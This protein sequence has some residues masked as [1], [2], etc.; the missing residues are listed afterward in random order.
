MHT[1]ARLLVAVALSCSCAPLFAASPVDRP[2]QPI[3]QRTMAKDD[4]FFTSEE[5]KRI[6]DS[7]VSWQNANG[8][9][10][11]AYDPTVPRPAHL[12]QPAG[13]VGDPDDQ[14]SDWQRTSTFDNGATTTEMRILARAHR[15]TQDQRYARAFERGLKF[16]FDSQYPN[17]G[18]PQRFPLEGNYGRRITFNDRLMVNVMELLRDVAEGKVAFTSADQRQRAREAFVRGVEA[19]LKCQIRA[20][21][22]RLT[23]WCQ[24]HDEVTFA[25][26][27]ARSYELPSVTAFESADVTL[28][29]MSL[30]KPDA[31]VREAI[32]AAIAWFE[33]SKIPGKR[34]DKQLDANGKVTD[35]VLSDD[36]GGVLW[37]RFYD[38]ETGKPF[39]CNR[40]GVKTDRYEDVLQERRAGYMW[41]GPWGIRVLEEYPRWKERV[42]KAKETTA[43]N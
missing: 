23:A 8:G 26:A 36:P 29:L 37:A 17:G 25:P 7:I 31:R 10:W 4:E 12:Q 1:P 24:Q 21:D 14:T 19:I 9:W 13:H 40:D 30:E 41:F 20:K 27:G 42:G 34:Y 28:L 32:E 15:L 18:W 3:L 33:S 39:F 43:E 16:I 35:R 38:L 11:K 2:S 5:G 22:G 6:V